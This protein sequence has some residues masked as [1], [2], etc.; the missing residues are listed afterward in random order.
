MRQLD[1]QE[2]A[3]D[4]VSLKRSG[5]VVMEY[6]EG[7][8]NKEGQ[9]HQQQ[10][11]Q[12]SYLPQESRQQQQ[13]QH[14]LVGAP[15]QQ[16]QQPW[17]PQQPH[18]Y[19]QQQ[20][21]RGRP[22]TQQEM[23][24]VAVPPVLEHQSDYHLSQ[25]Q[26]AQQ[27]QYIHH[28]HAAAALNA[29][30]SYPAGYAARQQYAQLSYQ[31]QLAMQQSMMAA[32]GA[33]QQPLLHHH[34]DQPSHIPPSQHPQ[35]QQPYIQPKAGR[36]PADRPLI[37]L[38]VSLI[39]TYKRINT[40]YYEER[41]A[42]RAARAKEKAQKGQGANNNGW[43]D[44]NYDYIITQGELFYGRYRIKERIGKGSFGQVVRAEDTETQKDVAI[45]IIKS[46]KPFLMQAKTEIELLTHLNDRDPDDQ[47]NIGTFLFHVVCVSIVLMLSS[48]SHTLL[49]LS[50]VRLITHFMYR[51]H[52]C[53]VFEMLSLNLYELLKNTQ[54][55]GVSLNLIRKF[56]KQVLKSLQFLQ[57]KDVDIIHC[58]LKPE[59][60]LLRHPK[61]SGVKVI[62]FGSSCRSN[63]RMYSYIQSR[64]YRS[65]E[66]MLG[67]PYS[68]SIDVWSLGCI[69]AEMHTGEPLFSG[70]DQFDQMQKIVKVR[71]VLTRKTSWCTTCGLTIFLSQLLG[72]VPEHMLDQSNDQHRLQFFERGRTPT[73]RDEWVVKQQSTGASRAASSSSPAQQA[74]QVVPS[75]DPIASLTEV[76]RAETHRKKKHPPSETGNSPRNYDMFVDLI[77]R[78]LSYDPRE[79]IKPDDALNHPF[80]SSGEQQ[81]QS[82][83]S[84]FSQPR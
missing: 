70:S 82:Q 54:F 12:I 80:I 7:E 38:S 28:H 11:Q 33:P 60:I 16:P 48:I 52:Q 34:M 41:D 57:R 51:N 4:R 35:L 45:K 75:S 43:D 21:Y 27:Q 62:D 13:P 19:G 53:L 44:E 74:K 15:S 42:R 46:K 40:V 83:G 9:Q 22:F 39:D 29:G 37:K 25:Q 77:Y 36:L 8:S 31:Q 55:G 58:D 6:S 56:A 65:P 18:V 79:R 47:H 68:V 17:P 10:Q 3:I 59:N 69:L 20:S 26:T 32:G 64:F 50:S 30:P 61:K 73:G 23:M 24:A 63:K 2:T 49:S 72:M 66:V 67:L 76:I 71:R 14:R 78:M 84:L 5:P 81:Q 1:Q